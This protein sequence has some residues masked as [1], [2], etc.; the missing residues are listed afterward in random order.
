MVLV[1]LC[2]ISISDSVRCM[3]K[4][5]E[6]QQNTHQIHHNCFLFSVL[7]ALFTLDY[8]LFDARCS[9]FGA[10]SS[11]LGIGWFLWGHI[12]AH[13]GHCVPSAD[14]QYDV[15]V[16]SFSL[17]MIKDS[18]GAVNATKN[19]QIVN[20]VVGLIPRSTM[21]RKFCK[22]DVTAARKDLQKQ[23]FSVQWVVVILKF[24]GHFWHRCHLFMMSLIEERVENSMTYNDLSH[25]FPTFSGHSLQK[26]IKN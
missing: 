14:I 21:D 17:G 25:L 15:L 5:P 6:R 11:V 12:W 24:I 23:A 26:V 8:S 1:I 4:M 18:C 9:V 10:R 22:Q 16:E 2:C 13:D 20:L 3:D 19:K 7:R